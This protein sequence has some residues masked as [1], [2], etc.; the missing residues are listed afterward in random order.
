MTQPAVKSRGSIAAHPVRAAVIAILLAALIACT[1]FV[2]IYDSATPKVGDFPFF[3]FYLLV[4]FPVMAVVMWIV[5]Q[6]QKG[7]RTSG[8][9]MGEGPS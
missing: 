9:D 5:T 7:M 3:Y 2:T 8:D 1:L 4:Y 6:L